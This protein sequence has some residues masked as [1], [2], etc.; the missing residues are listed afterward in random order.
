M[1]PGL[2]QLFT[3][4]AYLRIHHPIKPWFDLFIPLILCCLGF[5]IL[6]FLP[7]R[8][9]LFGEAGLVAHV[10]Q[11]L[12][13]L[14]GFYIA[15]LAAVAT[16]PSEVLDQGFAGDPVRITVRRQGKRKQIEIN[17]RRFLSYLFGYLAF[18][19]LF[20]FMVGMSIS[21]LHNNLATLLDQK[22]IDFVKPAFIFV[23]LFLIT[24]LM[25]TTLL[26]LHYLTDRIHRPPDGPLDSD[27]GSS[28]GSE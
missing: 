14:I 4:L 28:E 9:N 1:I 11:L 24:N 10:T 23:Y 13:M 17:R 22:L 26:G 20:L 5:G 16:F 7:G 25:V 15:A 21:V 27:S 12:Q 3:P 6:M 19:S 18:E 8:V 2:G